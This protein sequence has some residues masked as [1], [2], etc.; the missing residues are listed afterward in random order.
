M[1]VDVVAEGADPLHQQQQQQ[2][3]H[4][5]NEGSRSVVRVPVD[6]PFEL[7]QIASFYTGRSR[8]THLLYI[9]S[10]CVGWA[11]QALT[12]AMDAIKQHTL[13]VNL[14]EH[15]FHMYKQHC[16][17]IEAGQTT[18]ET[19]KAWF[20]KHSADGLTVH[21]DTAWCER[22]RKEE[23]QTTDKLE[24]ELKGYTTNLIKESIRMAHRD[25]ARHQ[26]R[27]GDLQGAIR[28][29][30]KS[31]EF[32]TTSQHVLEM[33]LGVI[34]VALELPNYSFVRNYVVKAESA[35]EALHQPNQSKPRQPQVNLPG[36]VAPAA[37]PI[38][39]AKEKERKSTVER[40]TVAGAVAML[41][42]SAY[43]QCARSL[44]SIGKEALETKEGHFIPPADIA[45]YA[46][47]TGL[48]TF[49]RNELRTRLLENANL[50]PMF[51]SEPYLRDSI[52]SFHSNNFKDGLQTLERH[53]LRQQL[54]LH[55]APHLTP[56]YDLIQSRA[57]LTYFAPFA[58]VSIPRMAEAFGWSEDG[59]LDVVMTLIDKGQ[60]QARIDSQS[61][62]LVA[63]NK[64][65]RVEAFKKA[66]KEGDQIQRRTLASQWRLKL[67][68][69]EIVV[70]VPKGRDQQQQREQQLM[71]A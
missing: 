50:R 66:L 27:S 26:Y 11:G 70:K 48:A 33:C 39:V 71:E 62:T 16:N 20:N 49:D 40:L 12:M 51:D 64:D 17:A 44:T 22:A 31:R 37:D 1:D 53:K 52:R 15:A 14:Y 28:S 61:R 63:K 10:V 43:D 30:S 4:S 13:D 19:A 68:Q 38:E 3:L 9:A 8:I 34:E 46:T 5:S 24:V 41:G 55:L 58:T 21:V 23:Q 45:L 32:C 69:H 36:M 67:I 6:C 65:A 59:L 42:Q 47:L 2:Q 60:L 54:D 57:V 35:L 56:L 29:Y 18:D 25:L 7:E